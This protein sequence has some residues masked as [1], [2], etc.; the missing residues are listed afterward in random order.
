MYHLW[1]IYKIENIQE[2]YKRLNNNIT[3]LMP[4]V[5]MATLLRFNLHQCWT[6]WE[7]VAENSARL[8]LGPVHAR[9]T[10][11]SWSL[12]PRAPPS[13]RR[14]LSSTTNHS[15]LEDV[16]ECKAV[17]TFFLFFLFVI[18]LH[19]PVWFTSYTA[20]RYLNYI[21]TLR[22]NFQ[23]TLPQNLQ[24]PVTQKT[25][26]PKLTWT[27]QWEACHPLAGEIQ[28]DSELSPIRLK[29]RYIIHM[30]YL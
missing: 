12:N 8:I 11:A 20:T 30:M 21:N 7:N 16:N 13:K 28:D 10:A 6:S 9:Y 27:S 3:Y 17:I 14:S 25:N 29:L 2:S 26:L 15:T 23:E 1:L 19:F 4:T 18:L 5:T 22:N 24:N